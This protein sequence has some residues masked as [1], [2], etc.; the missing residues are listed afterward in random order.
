MKI[1]EIS[2]DDR[3]VIH[4]IENIAGDREFT[5]I[6]LKKGK[7]IG[8]CIHK[9][10]EHFFVVS[11]KVFAILDINGNFLKFLK[12]EGDSGLILKGQGHAFHA[13]EDSIL[14]E[15][16]PTKEEKDF[17]NYNKELKKLVEEIN[18]N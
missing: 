7:A 9:A 11:G 10:D 2:S 14:I 3:R 6:H 12:S 18:D 5:I 15:F 13:L 8:G 4:L 17:G 1:K 16:G